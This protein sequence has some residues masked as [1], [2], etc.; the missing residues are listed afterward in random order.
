MLLKRISVYITRDKCLFFTSVGTMQS[1]RTA[2]VV[3]FIFFL[4]H[5]PSFSFCS[6]FRM[7]MTIASCF[8]LINLKSLIE[9]VFISRQSYR[10]DSVLFYFTSRVKQKERKT[11]ACRSTVFLSP[12]QSRACALN[13]VV[14]VVTFPLSQTNTLIKITSGREEKKCD[15]IHP[16]LLWGAQHSIL[17][18]SLEIVFSDLTNSAMF[19]WWAPTCNVNRRILNYFAIAY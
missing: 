9:S 6:V 3:I 5:F 1:Q 16:D 15:K 14:E 10:T 2:K 18:F 4:R 7:E 13:G 12:E 19:E 17:I 11:L 8:I